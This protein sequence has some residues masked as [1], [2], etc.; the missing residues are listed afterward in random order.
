MT[1]DSLRVLV[2]VLRVDFLH[3]VSDLLM[4]SPAPNLAQITQHKFPDATV[5][6]SED[7]LFAG[8]L[9]KSRSK[10]LFK[11]L[12]QDIF[13]DSGHFAKNIEIK[14]KTNHGS[15]DSSVHSVGVKLL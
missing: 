8:F 4:I 7:A 11:S 2:Q 3:C 1:R 5:D 14:F 10:N 13:L 9:D 15:D 12:K 6:E